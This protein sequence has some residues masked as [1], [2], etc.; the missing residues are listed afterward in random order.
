MCKLQFSFFYYLVFSKC[1]C[2]NK[3]NI[4]FSIIKTYFGVE[5]TEISFL[6]S[7]LLKS[8]FNIYSSMTN[9]HVH[10]LFKFPHIFINMGLHSRVFLSIFFYLHSFDLYCVTFMVESSIAFPCLS[11]LVEVDGDIRELFEVSTTL[12]ENSRIFMFFVKLDMIMA[13]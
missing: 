3:T 11:F 6:A 13:T 5:S 9:H 12:Y 8:G 4:C 10:L 2:I 7:N 1:T